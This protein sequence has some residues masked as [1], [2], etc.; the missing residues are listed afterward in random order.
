MGT[1]ADT[2]AAEAELPLIWGSSHS[3]AIDC[4][5]RGCPVLVRAHPAYSQRPRIGAV[6]RTGQTLACTVQFPDNGTATRIGAPAAFTVPDQSLIYTVRTS[7][8]ARV[9]PYVI[10]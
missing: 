1:D 4:K 6:A 7:T 9:S 2:Y 8:P 10:P 5:V 3:C